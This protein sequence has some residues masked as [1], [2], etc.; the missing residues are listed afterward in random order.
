MRISDWSSDVCSSD[1]WRMLRR[2]RRLQLAAVDLDAERCVLVAYA[3]G[4][5]KARHRR[6]RGQRLAAKTHPGD[7]LEIVEAA[8]L[9]GSMRGHRQRPF[10]DVDAAAVVAPAAQPRATGLEVPPHPR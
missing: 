8:D 9:A 6:H 7:L 3:R 5:R 2:T 1:L 4:Q 10:V